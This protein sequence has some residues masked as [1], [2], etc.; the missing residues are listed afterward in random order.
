LAHALKLGASDQIPDTSVVTFNSGGNLNSAFLQ[1]N[2]F[3]DTVQGIQTTSGQ[4]AVIENS[5]ALTPSVLTVDTAGHDYLYDGIIRNTG[6]ALGLTVAGAT[7]HGD[8]G[9]LCGDQRF[10][11]LVE[12]VGLDDGSDKLHG[13]LV[14]IE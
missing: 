3:N 2:G 11:D 10:A 1:L 5:S 12:F 7:A 9:D 13:F 14:E 6:A 8:A 4:A